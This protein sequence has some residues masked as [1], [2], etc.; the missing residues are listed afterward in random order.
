[1]T[2]LAVVTVVTNL[3]VTVVTGD[4]GDYFDE[5]L[6]MCV[7]VV[8]HPHNDVFYDLLPSIPNIRYLNVQESRQ[9]LI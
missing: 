5:Q 1:M 3:A 6:L 4:G 9:D 7:Y 8:V 2:N